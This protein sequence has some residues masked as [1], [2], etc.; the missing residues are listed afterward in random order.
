MRAFLLA[1]YV[2]VSSTVFL[3]QTTPPASSTQAIYTAQA[4]SCQR[5]FEHIQQNGAKAMPD[6]TPT[7]IT[8]GEINAWLSSGKANLPQGVKRLQ[9][10]GQPGV[11]QATA[12]VD[13][14]Q[15]VAEKQPS[16]PLLYLFRGTHEVQA[17]AHASGSGGMG[18]VHIDSV[19]LDGVAVPRVALEYFV[20]RY[21]TPKHPGIGI[22]SEFELP[23]RID[24]AV[25]G[26][27]QLT[28]TQK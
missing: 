28:I 6:Q 13:F 15:I 10:R 11:I 16:N 9:L 14:D 12:Y 1:A 3:S 24:I 25:V 21:I 27:R 23:Y 18:R 19:S 7:V 5:K 17:S 20:E 8:E 4:N 22:D 26:D 2:A